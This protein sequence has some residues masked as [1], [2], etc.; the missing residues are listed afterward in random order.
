MVSVNKT[1]DTKFQ[2]FIGYVRLR[3]HH[4]QQKSPSFF[5]DGPYKD[6]L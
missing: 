3:I 2:Q 4:S 5:N 6:Q 1:L